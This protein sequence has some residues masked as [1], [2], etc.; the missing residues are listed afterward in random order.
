MVRKI[1]GF[2]PVPRYCDF[3]K[4]MFREVLLA[5]G[6]LVVGIYLLSLVTWRQVA[7]GYAIA[8]ALFLWAIWRGS[9]R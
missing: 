5:L 1:F 3:N 7:V 6:L 4:A 9:V 2:I 8:F